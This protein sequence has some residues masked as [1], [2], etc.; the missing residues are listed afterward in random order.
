MCSKK[1]IVNQSGKGVYHMYYSNRNWIALGISVIVTIV[2]VALLTVFIGGSFWG[3]MVIGETSSPVYPFSLQN[4]MHLL[5]FIGLGQLWIRWL[6]TYEENVF[7]SKSGFLP[8]ED[9]VL[10]EKDEDIE[11]IRVNVSNAAV[12]AE[13]FLPDL[14]NNSILQYSKSHSISD[15]IS[16]LNSNLELNIHRLDLNY[17]IIRYLVWAIPTFGF[18]GTVI[19]IAYALGR[20]D[21]NKFMGASTEKVIVFKKITADLGFAFG[22]TIVALALSALLVFLWNVV[23]RGEENVL[24][25]AGK[26]VLMNL[27]NRL[28]VPNKRN[29]Q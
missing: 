24:N 13:A 3:D 28:H 27:I 20:M 23:Q 1:I 9:G 29:S 11:A 21:I 8:E 10:L 18:M 7:L 4:L 14:I 12:R 17:S 22:T 25:K 6:F 16:V 15:T 26:Y 19:G 2:V 5:F